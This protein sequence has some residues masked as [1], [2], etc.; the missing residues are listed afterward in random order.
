M[1]SNDSKNKALGDKAL[2]LFHAQE[3]KDE[4]LSAL[5]E[6]EPPAPKDTDRLLWRLDP[7]ETFSDW[8]IEIVILGN[9]KQNQDT[10]DCCPT[11]IYHVHKCLLAAGP[12]RSEYFVRLFGEGGGRFSE[13]QTATSRIEL[14]QFAADA[15]PV[16]LD[17]LY[18]PYLR[19][20]L[21]TENATALHWLAHYFEI[22]RLKR[23]AQTFWQNDLTIDTCVIYYEHSFY[24]QDG[25]ILNHASQF[26]VEQIDELKTTSQLLQVPNPDFWLC[27]LNSRQMTKQFS[28]LMSKLI[29]SFCILNDVDAEMFSN[30]T[31]EEHLPF[32]HGTVALT[33]IDMERRI[34]SSDASMLSSLQQRCISGIAREWETVDVSSDE[35]MTIM[36]RQSPLVLGTIL[37]Q[38]LQSARK[39]AHDMSCF[40]RAGSTASVSFHA[41][42]AETPLEM[43]QTRNHAMPGK[44]IWASNGVFYKWYPLFY[45]APA[46][47]EPDGGRPGGAGV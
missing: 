46:D 35:S 6:A 16:M 45:Y 11:T 27:A 3:C 1:S 18:A 23:E 8:T 2:T 29:A 5:E 31:S 47:D 40:H 41:T 7:T 13:S 43:P 42:N 14:H 36:Q 17:F 10:S 20:N 26:C 15:F 38:S 37:S 9:I 12:H 28:L 24:L 32:I 30:L 25:I 19:I 39:M 34:A 22:P 44:T 21:H 33:L 4:D